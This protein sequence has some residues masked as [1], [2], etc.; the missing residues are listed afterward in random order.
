MRGEGEAGQ[1]I[2]TTM[3]ERY[4]DGSSH[5]VCDIC[6]NCKDCEDCIC[7]RGLWY[8]DCPT[9]GQVFLKKGEECNWCGAR[10][11]PL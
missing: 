5:T 10:E 1:R 4:G 9:E 7:D 6:G 2:M 8:H 11:V 3:D